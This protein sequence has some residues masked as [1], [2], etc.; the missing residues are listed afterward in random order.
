MKRLIILLIII[1][2]VFVIV[3]CADNDVQQQS[4]NQQPYISGGC[5]VSN[6]Q[7]DEKINQLPI[8]ME[9]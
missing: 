8:N 2:M 3:G 4:N 9:M 1:V 7:E 6:P 5:S